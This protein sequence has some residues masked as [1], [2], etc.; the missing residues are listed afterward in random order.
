MQVPTPNKHRGTSCQ[1]ER[2]IEK[3]LEGYEAIAWC[4]FMC[5]CPLLAFPLLF[6]KG[7][8]AA[9]LEELRKL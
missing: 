2:R 8:T 7:F 3:K 9:Y 6:L 5:A 4:I 1:F